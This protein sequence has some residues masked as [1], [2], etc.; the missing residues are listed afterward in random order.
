M[1]GGVIR[2]IVKFLRYL[3]RDYLEESSSG[4]WLLLFVLCALT[5]CVLL[6]LCWPLA[7]PLGDGASSF[8]LVDIFFQTFSLFGYLPAPAH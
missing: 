6:L 2:M 8:S 5:A 3:E 4:Y 1:A 7:D